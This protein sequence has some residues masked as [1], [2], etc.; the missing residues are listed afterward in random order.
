MTREKLEN[1][2]RE[3][4]VL[5]RASV[6]QLLFKSARLLNEYAIAQMVAVGHE[7]IRVTHT[8]LFPHVDLEGTRMSVLAERVGVS[9]QAIGQWVDELEGMGLLERVPDPDDGRAKLVRF[10]RDGESL[11]DGVKALIAIEREFAGVLGEERWQDLG[12]S[13]ATLIEDL[14]ERMAAASLANE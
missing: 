11:I 13:L 5:K 14:E 2:R 1:N 12:E 8:K 6:A 9:K 10:A 4:E 3:L 7:G